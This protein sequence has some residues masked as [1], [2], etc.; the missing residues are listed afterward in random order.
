MK[1][2]H[3]LTTAFASLALLSACS[4]VPPQQKGSITGE[5]WQLTAVSEKKGLDQA[6]LAL[7]ASLMTNHRTFIGK[8][9]VLPT[10]ST[11]G[12]PP[13][14]KKV[15]VIVFL[16]GSSGIKPNL[17]FE[18]WQTAMAEQGYAS[19]IFDSM[20]LENRLQYQSPIDR[21]T[22]EKIHSLRTSEIQTV[23]G[24]LKQ[25]PWADTSRLILAGTSEGA[26]S[27]A[28]YAN[29]DFRARMIFSWSCEDNYF[30]K[31]HQTA[32]SPGLPTL[33]IISSQDPYFSLANAYLDNPEATGNCAQTLKTNP[34]A[35]VVLIPNAPHTLINLPAARSAVEGFL[36]KTVPAQ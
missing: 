8:W 23:L 24:A 27:V 3:R 16:H 19:I 9:S 11:L 21:E 22:Y 35:E 2:I 18:S 31:G 6:S 15:P 4:T 5:A 34:N 32:V 1:Y 36:R 28:R 14:Q 10:L 25:V 12:S 20:T 7:P 33:N 17:G 30:V 13:T 29:P 26:V